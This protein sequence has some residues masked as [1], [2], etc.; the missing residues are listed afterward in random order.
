L[1]VTGYA[2]ILPDQTDVSASLTR[3]THLSI[4]LVTAPVG[5]SP[6]IELDVIKEDPGDARVLECAVAGEASFESGL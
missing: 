5:I 4:P 1:I 3:H 2:E 6:K